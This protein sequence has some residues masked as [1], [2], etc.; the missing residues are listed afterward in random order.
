MPVEEDD[1]KGHKRRTTVNKDSGRGTPQGAPI[2]P[3]MAN[4]YMR[5]FLLGWKQQ[6]WD[7][8]LQSHIVNYADD[9]A[10]RAREGAARLGSR[11]ELH[12]G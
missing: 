1:G 10:P 4:L 2:S 7:R 9:C 12:N 8:K 11:A 5:R 3:L 6:G